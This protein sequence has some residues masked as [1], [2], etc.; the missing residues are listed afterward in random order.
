MVAL[1]WAQTPLLSF[2]GGGRGFLP[3]GGDRQQDLSYCK[4]KEKVGCQRGLGQAGRGEQDGGG[5]GQLPGEAGSLGS[6]VSPL[7]ITPAPPC[8]GPGVALHLSAE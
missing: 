8:L 3:W 4:E 5:G 7:L 2:S 1:P 6:R